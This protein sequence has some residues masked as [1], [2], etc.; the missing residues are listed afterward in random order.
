MATIY[1][2]A[3]ETGLSAATVS[4]ALQGSRLIGGEV[5]AR[6]EACATALGYVARTI[7][8]P[9]SRAILHVRLVLP[10]PANPARSLFYD[11]TDL[12]EG[13]RTGFGKSSIN[14]VCDLARPDFEPF[15]NKKGGDTDAFVF[16]FHRPDNS[17]VAKL[18]EEQVPFVVL[19]RNIPDLPC[20]GLDQADGIRSLLGHLSAGIPKLRPIFVSVERLGEIHDE[21]SHAFLETATAMGLTLPPEPVRVFP[22][23]DSINSKAITKIA[24]KA[25]AIVA[26]NDIVGML[27]LEEVR[28]LGI[29][30]PEKIAVTGFDDSPLRRLSRPLLTTFSLP[31]REL[32]QAAGRRLAAKILDREPVQ[33]SALLRGK[34]LQGG[35]TRK[36]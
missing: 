14:L 3:R 26:V 18:R 19:N 8:R 36:I 35:T 21:R 5:R 30:V 13:L 12:I 27:V 28:G 24:A 20:L 33:E 15:P 31:V 7:R 29:M 11:V 25:N 1:D 2:I 10:K 23:L 17:T 34:L 32:A 9:R 6:V 22:H 4:R 16:A